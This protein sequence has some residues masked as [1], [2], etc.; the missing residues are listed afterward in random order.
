MRDLQRAIEIKKKLNKVKRA[1]LL[2]KKLCSGTPLPS[3]YSIGAKYKSR[4][5]RGIGELKFLFFFQSHIGDC[6][7]HR[8][9]YFN[10]VRNCRRAIEIK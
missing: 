2:S 4:A 3:R 8:N 6:A 9:N 5:F 10:D 7:R 1:T